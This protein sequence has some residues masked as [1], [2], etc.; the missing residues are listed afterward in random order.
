MLFW[1]LHKYFTVFQQKITFIAEI[2]SKILSP[3]NVVTWMPQW[4]CFRT[5]FGSQGVK[6][7]ETLLKSSRQHFLADFP[8]ISN[9]LSCVSCLLVGSEIL[10][11]LFDML[12]ADHKYSCHNWEKFLQVKKQVSLKVKRFSASF[13][14]F[15]K[16]I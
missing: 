1:N 8:L 12:A 5:T 3:R 13:I 9:K 2:F 6:W 7:S 4:S 11:P 16:Y 14:A 15:L 10:G